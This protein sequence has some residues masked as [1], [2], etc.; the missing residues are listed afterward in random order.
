ML[1]FIKNIFSKPANYT[2]LSSEE[3][4]K[5]L[6][7]AKKHIILDVRH[8]HEFD[9]EKIH[10]ALNM[11]IRMPTFKDKMKHYDTKKAYYVYCQ[12]GARS[13]KACRALE[14]ISFGRWFE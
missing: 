9:A 6:I 3:F 4:E 8:K 7:T 11:D 1:D 2:K 5:A 12:S 14:A 10:N 13:T